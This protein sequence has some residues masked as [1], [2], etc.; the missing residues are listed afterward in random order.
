MEDIR[1]KRMSDAT[2]FF[3]ALAGFAIAALVTLGV[4]GTVYRIIA[5]DGWL[6]QA[7]GQ[8][9]AGGVAAIFAL[10]ALAGFAW[11]AREWVSARHR[12]RFSEVFVYVFAGAGLLYVALMLAYG[13]F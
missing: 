12:N 6:A 7:Y 11:I 2:I 4:G 10:A 3:Q 5:P 9:L 13:G 1:I 8:G